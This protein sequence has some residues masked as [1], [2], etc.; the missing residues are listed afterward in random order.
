MVTPV[1]DALAVAGFSDDPDLTGRLDR[2]AGEHPDVDDTGRMVRGGTGL[3][4]TGAYAILGAYRHPSGV[5]VKVEQNTSNGI[6]HAPVAVVCD[7][8]GIPLVAVNPDDTGLLAAEAAHAAGDPSLYERRDLEFA[9]RSVGFEPDRGDGFVRGTTRLTL[10]A[11]TLGTM[12]LLA[13]TL[14]S[15]LL[16][17]L[18]VLR[19]G[20]PLVNTYKKKV[21]DAVYGN[22]AVAPPSTIYHGLS[23]TT[24]A[25]DGTGITEPSGN[26]YARVGMTNN[27]TNYGGATAANP[28]IKDNDQ[29]ITWAAASGVGWGTVT[30]WTTHDALTVGNPIDWAAL[31]SSQTIT[32]GTTVSFANGQWISQIQGA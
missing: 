19:P 29:P 17:P 7:Q 14:S 9:L 6:V 25:Q 22:T 18:V 32:A 13:P 1:G 20:L 5:T 16:V 8:D 30:H 31:T 21:I 11:L 10:G 12:L 15:R 26:G 28:S 3:R 2:D 4:A 27:T 24:P 23:T